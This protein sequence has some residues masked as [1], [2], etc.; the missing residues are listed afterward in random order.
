MQGALQATLAQCGMDD[1]SGLRRELRAKVNNP[2]RVGLIR[3]VPCLRYRG[4]YC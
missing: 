2:S 4:A 3:R 1:R